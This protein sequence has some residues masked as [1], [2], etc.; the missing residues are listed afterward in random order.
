MG[1]TWEVGKEN[2][3]VTWE[4]AKEDMGVTWEMKK[5]CEDLVRKHVEQTL[6]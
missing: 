6:S 2:M 4:V 3:G 1:V 5:Y